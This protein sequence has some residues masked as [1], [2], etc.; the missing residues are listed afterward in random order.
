[1]EKEVISSREFID[2]FV[3]CLEKGE[4]FKLK[5]CVVEG[6]VDILNIY[7]MIKDKELKG[8]Y[9]EKKD[10]E[11]VV[12]INI[13]VDIYNVEFNGD[14]RFFVNMEYQIVISVFNGNAYFRVITFKG[15]VY[16][17]RT[18]FNGDVDFIDTIFEENAY[19]SVTAF[20]GNI[21]NFSGTIFNK[22]SH[23]KSTTF[24]GNTYFS[25]TTFNIA[26]F[27]NSTF[28][29]HVYF[30]DISFNLLSFTDCRFRDDV[31]LKK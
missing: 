1:M 7:E 21:I 18:I 5:D 3:E 8:G 13:K 24:E 19:F 9:I 12:N 29:S 31:S 20:K 30:D 6:N 4:D 26:E 15:S 17:I 14:F 27:Y 16:F 28:K 25:V 10:D 22:E 11:I 23:F 2:R